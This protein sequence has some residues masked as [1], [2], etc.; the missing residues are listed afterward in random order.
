MAKLEYS[1]EVID[2]LTYCSRLIGNDARDTFNQHTFCEWGDLNILSPI[3]QIFYAS[4]KAVAE[5][6][7][8][9]MGDLLRINGE[10]T[11]FG[12]S[13]APQQQIQSY[14]VDFY[15]VWSGYAYRPIQDGKKVIVECDS[16]QWHER[17]ESERRYEKKRDRDLA[18]LGLHTFRFTGK[19][20][21]EEPFRPAIEV[22]QFVTGESFEF[23]K[24][25]LQCLTEGE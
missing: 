18:R 20:I 15:I 5:L 13:I 3:E 17:S 14:R 21:K 7:S 23:F 8:I 11:P 4:V 24:D 22:L 25:Q 1:K 9:P 2:F 6:Q 19:E 16:Q 12:L 10:D